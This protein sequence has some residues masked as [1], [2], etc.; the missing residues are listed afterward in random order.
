MRRLWLPVGLCAALALHAAEFDVEKTESPPPEEVS[1][2]I[3]GVIGSGA[4]RVSAGDKEVAE[5]WLRE[6]IPAKDA[7]SGELGVSFGQLEQGVLMGVVRLA[8]AWQDYKD[9][10]VA[11]GVYTLRYA[12]LPQDG[13]HMGVSIYRDYMLL[14]PAAHDKEV[15][16]SWT[17]DELYMQSNE[18][19]GQ[20]HPGVLALFPVYDEISEP[21]V[22]MNDMDQPT[23]AV[24]VGSLT[25]GLVIRGHG[26]I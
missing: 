9:L 19:T 26:E 11:A 25:L 13:N 12:V 3:R 18:S 6:E 17:A 24:K 10:K 21:R 8:E 7:P 5:F 20:P 4:L 16:V 2:A 1:Q 15:D 14:I 22:I 23:L